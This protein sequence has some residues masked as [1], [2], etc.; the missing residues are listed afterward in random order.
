MRSQKNEATTTTTTKKKKRRNKSYGRHLECWISSP[1]DR[2]LSKFFLRS[3]ACV[4]VRRFAPSLFLH[5]L[6]FCLF[7]YLSFSLFHVYLYVYVYMFAAH[8]LDSCALGIY[9]STWLKSN[10]AATKPVKLSRGYPGSSLYI[11]IYTD[12]WMAISP[13]MHA[14]I[15]PEHVYAKQCAYFSQKPQM[16]IQCS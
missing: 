9:H 6:F 4:H 12:T 3:R 14:L 1:P 7:H 8:S 13:I 15:V 16:Q 2:S 10:Q 11:C 5:D